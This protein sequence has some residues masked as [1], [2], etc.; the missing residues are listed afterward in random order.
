MQRGPG[1]SIAFHRRGWDFGMAFTLQSLFEDPDFRD[2]CEAAGQPNVDDPEDL[3]HGPYFQSLD[4][5]T[6]RVWSQRTSSHEAGMYAL[7]ALSGSP[8]VALVY[9]QSVPYPHVA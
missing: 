1:T 6:G 8:T 9:H 5:S 2:S 3:M 4:S 7:G